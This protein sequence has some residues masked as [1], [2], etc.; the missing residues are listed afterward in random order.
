MPPRPPSL[1]EFLS[2][3]SVQP[4]THSLAGRPRRLGP[5]PDYVDDTRGLLG[6]RSTDQARIDRPGRSSLEDLAWIDLE[7]KVFFAHIHK[8]SGTA[9]DMDIKRSAGVTDCGRITRSDVCEEDGGVAPRLRDFWSS[10]AQCSYASCE[11]PLGWVYDSLHSNDRG[12]PSLLAMYREPVA[13]CRSS[14]AYDVLWKNVGN[15]SH[16]HYVRLRCASHYVGRFF[17]L[18]IRAN[19][20][21]SALYQRGRDN[22]QAAAHEVLRWL[23]RRLDFVGISERYDASLCLLWYVT[24]QRR[25]FQKA[26]PCDSPHRRKGL[27]QHTN[28]MRG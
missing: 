15:L 20:K 18:P 28:S 9:F 17:G 2:N 4:P 8:A 16:E 21:A 12:D 7:G 1:Q 10:T 27:G 14:W 25:Q 26:C 24:G 19:R 11:T 23:L 3:G 6:N 22:P 5:L 13:R